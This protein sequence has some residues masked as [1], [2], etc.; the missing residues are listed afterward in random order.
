MRYRLRV[1]LFALSLS[2]SLIP[3]IG[4]AG[5]DEGVTAYEKKDYIAALQEFRPIAVQGN[6]LAQFYLGIIYDNGEGVPIDYK[7]ALKW[8]RLA[9]DQGDTRA[10]FK[11]GMLYEF[12]Q[13][14]PQDYKEAVKWYRLAADQGNAGGQLSLGMMYEHGKGVPQDDKEA[15]KWSRLAADQGNAVGQWNLGTMYELGKGVPQDDK[16]AVKWYRLAADQGS[17]NGQSYLGRMYEFGKGVPQDYKEAVRWYRL[18]ADQGNA[19][20]QLNLG[21][22]Y[23]L[24]KGVPQDDKEAVKWYRLAAD[25]GYG[26][27]QRNLA[28][29]YERGKGV[30]SDRI[31][32]YALYNLSAPESRARLAKSMPE[33]E[34][35]AAQ[36]LTREIAKPGNLLITLDQYT[37][38]ASGGK[39]EVPE[40]RTSL[41]AMHLVFEHDSFGVSALWVMMLVLWAIIEV[42]GA[43]RKKEFR[44]RLKAAAVWSTVVTSI[45]SVGQMTTHQNAILQ[46]AVC[47]G[48]Y[49]TVACVIYFIRVRLFQRWQKHKTT[50]NEIA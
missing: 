43:L 35:E 18:A 19:G 46:L 38:D 29:M 28:G 33:N 12:G 49:G 10:Q 36:N 4:L 30:A 3:S 31:V 24:G 6:A 39:Y 25:Q 45:T 13:G 23:E 2:C 1:I 14:V 27:G 5:Q 21:T 11:I 48:L 15:V 40:V 41:T 44:K 47:L 9:S 26:E 22:M 17:V 34:I 32:A 7:E 50:T 37:K 42:I 16:E 8:Y 20:G